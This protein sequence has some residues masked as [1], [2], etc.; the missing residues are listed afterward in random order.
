M[1]HEITTGTE[2]ARIVSGGDCDAGTKH[3]EQDLFDAERE[4]FLK[5]AA[6][7]ETQARIRSML[8]D[9]KALRN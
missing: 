1:P 6:T 9:G 8:D 3:S 5:L 4:S 2:I 7:A